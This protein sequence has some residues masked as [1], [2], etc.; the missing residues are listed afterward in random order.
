MAT[1]VF[2]SLG[3]NLGDRASTLRRASAELQNHALPNSW[4]VSSLYETVPVGGAGPDYLNAV[5]SFATNLFSGELHQI[6]IQLEQNAGRIRGAL[7]APRTL[8]LDLLFYGSEIIS[9]SD[10]IVPHARLEQRAFVLVPLCEIDPKWTH[11]LSQKTVKDML[12][13]L[14]E[15]VIS[16]VRK[17]DTDSFCETISN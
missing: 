1:T 13:E 10:L 8:D 11:P 4:K 3:A 9:T 2:I 5:C 12:S 15:E 16:G 6:L 17:Y 14:T 7:N